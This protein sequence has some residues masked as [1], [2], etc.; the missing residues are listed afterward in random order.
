M[1]SS[2]FSCQFSTGRHLSTIAHKLTAAVGWSVTVPVA[3]NGYVRRA[4]T[5]QWTFFPAY[6]P[7]YEQEEFDPED[8]GRW[9]LRSSRNYL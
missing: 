6:M 3:N 4:V 7:Q 1:P 9:S 5:L 2:N 8:G